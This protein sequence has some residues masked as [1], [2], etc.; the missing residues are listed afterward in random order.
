MASE[1]VYDTF[2]VLLSIFK[3]WQSHCKLF[4]YNKKDN[5]DNHLQWK[6]HGF[7][8]TSECV[9]DHSEY[10]WIMDE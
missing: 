7:D 3:A 2:M 8:I 4:Q 6:S 9:D 1:D 10:I 5:Y